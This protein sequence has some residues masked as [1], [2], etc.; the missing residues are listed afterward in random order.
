MAEAVAADLVL[1]RSLRK[2]RV[3]LD[4]INPLERLRDD[5][6]IKA[7]FRLEQDV[8]NVIKN[9]MFIYLQCHHK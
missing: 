6:D 8:N 5:T 4:R 7:R 1:R 9:E 3:F 2:Q